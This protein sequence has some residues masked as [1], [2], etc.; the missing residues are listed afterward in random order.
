M[1]ADELIFRIRQAFAYP[2]TPEQASALDTFGQFMSDR[3]A[4]VV[5]VLRGSAGTGKTTL[6]GA[7]VRGLASVGQNWH[8]RGAPPRC[9][10]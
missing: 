3:R 4:H 8:P 2:L 1:I 9:S 5:M 10:R 7:M 6:A